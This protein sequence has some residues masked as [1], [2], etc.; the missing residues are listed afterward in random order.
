MK[1]AMK[2]LKNRKGETLIESMIAILVFTLSSVMLYTMAT[3][4]SDINL[5]AK[6]ADKDFQAQVVGVEQ[7]KTVKDD[8]GA[9]VVSKSSGKV[10]VS[11]TKSP[12]YGVAKDMGS[13]TVDVY[14]SDDLCAYYVP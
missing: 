10:S 1:T 5:T 13:V 7:G 4:A 9:T 8:S 3:A 14:K 11:I 6:K 2:K 12:A